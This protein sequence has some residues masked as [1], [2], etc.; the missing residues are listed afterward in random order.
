MSRKSNL[1]TLS[2]WSPRGNKA[3]N[4]G[5]FRDINTSTWNWA[6][7]L[8]SRLSGT[9]ILP[10][11]WNI[12]EDDREGEW[13]DGV[14]SGLIT[15]ELPSEPSRLS[16][17]AVSM[18][19]ACFAARRS[20][21][22]GDSWWIPSSGENEWC[23]SAIDI[24]WCSV[25]AGFGASGRCAR[26]E[27]NCEGRDKTSWRW[28]INEH[29]EPS[30]GSFWG[31]VFSTMWSLASPDG[32]L[33]VM[34][35]FALGTLA[36][37]WTRGK[38]ARRCCCVSS[39]ICGMNERK[40]TFFELLHS[41]TDF[42]SNMVLSN[43]SKRLTWEAQTSFNIVCLPRLWPLWTNKPSSSHLSAESKI[44]DVQSLRS[45]SLV[46]SVVGRLARRAIES[47]RPDKE[48]ALDGQIL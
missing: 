47:I 5:T 23:D 44:R 8:G 37:S 30:S 3:Q 43:S 11:M 4:S 38:F 35:S 26:I 22:L 1:K 48:E 9:R 32:P 20:L 45:F 25:R 21:C 41:S 39:V 17:S 16:A 19:V 7:V 14:A 28:S 29:S 34:R 33:W 24:L 10:I 27:L 36:F 18:L 13:T 31:W 15:V 2:A 6:Q 12:V 46:A 40:L 42:P